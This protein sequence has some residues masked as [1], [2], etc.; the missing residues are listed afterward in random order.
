MPAFDIDDR[1]VILVFAVMLIHLRHRA[2]RN[3]YLA[4]L[5]NIPGTLLHELAHLIVGW[6]GGAR[7]VGFTVWPRAAGFGTYVLGSV[8][9]E[10]LGSWN[11]VPS[12]LAPL[13]LLVVAYHLED[14]F[15]GIPGV[16]WPGFAG[17]V[18]LQ[19]ILIENAIPSR[20]DLRLAW[21]ARKGLALYGAVAAVALGVLW[22]D[23]FPETGP[24]DGRTEPAKVPVSR[25]GH[26]PA[27]TGFMGLE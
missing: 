22:S 4:A 7:P 18:L 3:I 20:Q 25:D 16:S 14:A 24:W 26:S 17:Y 11:T 9:F 8:T 5:V 27:R 13:L 12:A 23:R 10:R 2:Y 19:T 15:A 1:F 21:R 6:L